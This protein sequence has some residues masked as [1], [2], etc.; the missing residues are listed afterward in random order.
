MFHNVRLSKIIH[1]YLD[2]D[3]SRHIYVFRFINIYMYVGDARK[4]YIV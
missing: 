2:V 3:E 1:I 4:S